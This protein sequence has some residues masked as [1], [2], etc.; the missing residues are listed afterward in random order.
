MV[1]RA[2]FI[3]SLRTPSFTTTLSALVKS[4]VRS[5]P[6]RLQTNSGKPVSLVHRSHS[7]LGP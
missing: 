6:V 1:E 3:E 2:A 4:I 5:S 7:P